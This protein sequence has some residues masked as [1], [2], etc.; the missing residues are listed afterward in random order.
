MAAKDGF[1]IVKLQRPIR[2]TVCSHSSVDMAAMLSDVHTLLPVWSKEFH[3]LVAASENGS[4]PDMRRRDADACG[5]LSD[6][7]DA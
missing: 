6:Q 5:Q 4:P 2:A 7:N 1:R 3:R